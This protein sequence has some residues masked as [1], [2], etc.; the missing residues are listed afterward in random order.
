M[1]G[2]TS[3]PGEPRW[4]D[5]IPEAFQ[6][7]RGAMADAAH[8]MPSSPEDPYSASTRR[9]MW[10]VASVALLCVVSG[11]GVWSRGGGQEVSLLPVPFHGR[12]AAEKYKHVAL[13]N[14][15]LVWPQNTREADPAAARRLDS[16]YQKAVRTIVSNLRRRQQKV[17]TEASQIA[18]ALPN[19]CM[20]RGKSFHEC[21]G[22]QKTGAKKPD[23]VLENR[24]LT[25]QALV[26]EPPN[27]YTPKPLG[28][29]NPSA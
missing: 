7:P 19:L 26:R 3:I 29:P 28:K 11:A 12:T 22:C 20:S 21:M 9:R 15:A 14:P 17:S 8:R 10:A 2:L 1:C 18:K 6:A 23:F 24:D 4:K 13:R 5:G 16:Q 27:P 25:C